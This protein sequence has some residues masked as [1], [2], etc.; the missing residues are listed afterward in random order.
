MVSIG[1]RVADALVQRQNQEC[2]F[3]GH[4]RL[5]EGDPAGHVAL[6][7]YLAD[8]LG[9]L[10]FQADRGLQ[11]LHAGRVQ[12]RQMEGG[13]GGPGVEDNERRARPLSPTPPGTSIG[14]RQR[15]IG[16][17]EHDIQVR[18]PRVQGCGQVFSP[19]LVEV[20][21]KHEA[22]IVE[23]DACR[24]VAD[25]TRQHGLRSS[26]HNEPA[27]QLSPAFRNAR[28]L[29][30]KAPIDD[31]VAG[32]SQRHGKCRVAMPEHADPT[33]Q[34]VD[35]PRLDFQRPLL[36][37]AP[38]VAAGM[39]DS[40]GL[41]SA[42]PLLAVQGEFS[43]GRARPQVAP[44]GE[45]PLEIAV[46]EQILLRGRSQGSCTKE[47]KK[48]GNHWFPLVSDRP[49]VPDDRAICKRRTEECRRVA[50]DRNRPET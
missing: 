11:P 4:Q 43:A 45:S 30:G 16:S 33:A 42:M 27:A 46:D 24:A 38:V 18:V 29:A 49:I 3:V 25:Q 47:R 28:R 32:I 40:H 5:R 48:A 23:P 31:L 39:L 9:L 2:L 10:R 8:N 35:L 13:V 34:F 22:G 41:G 17:V 26:W 12:H 1:R 36:G 6:G 37:E 14:K 20:A 44:A 50:L 15:A 7:G 19:H 21:L